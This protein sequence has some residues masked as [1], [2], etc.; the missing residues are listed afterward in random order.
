[1]KH[2]FRVLDSDLHT[3]EPDG[4]W[5]QYLDEPVKKFAP[6]FT[7]R[8]EG[9]PNQPV[10]SVG[11]VEIAEM[12]KR[13]RTAVVG[14][15]LQERAFARHPHYALAHSRGYDAETHLQAMDIE[16]IDVAVVYGT[17]GRQVLMHD[18]H[19]PEVAAALARAHNNWTRDFCAFNPARLKFAA[20]IAF[21]DVGLA[22][23]EARRAVRELGA[24]AVIGT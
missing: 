4:L 5:E 11:N 7:R 3:M 8:A 24:V 10:I 18:D 16:G 1:M 22:V 21:H 12:S 14:K 19:V 2:G 20:Q 17:R 13:A 6:R 15:S 23:Q 9:A